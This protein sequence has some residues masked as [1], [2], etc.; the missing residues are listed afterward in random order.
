MGLAASNLDPINSE[1]VVL[2]DYNAG[3]GV[4]LLASALT[5]YHFGAAESTGASYSGIDMRAEVMLLSRDVS[6]T[7]STDEASKTLSHPEPW[8]CRVIVSDFFEPDL[9]YRAGS[10]FMDNVS[11]FNCSQADTKEAAL[12]F[13]N[14]I[15][16]TKIFRNGAISSGKG[17]GIHVINSRQVTFTDSVI[18]DFVLFGHH[19]KGSTQITFENNIMNGI[20]PNL[21]DWRDQ[22]NLKWP[23]PTGG[24][25]MV[26]TNDL[27][28][29]NN[30]AASMW[31]SGFRLPSHA[32]GASSTI[33]DNIAHS[34]SGMGVIVY[35]SAGPCSEFSS[36]RGYKNQLATVLMAVEGEN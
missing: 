4:A 1:T 31:H 3:T 27:V 23:I 6:I 8:G 19:S 5:G 13:N 36:F 32:C 35:S 34:I 20:R 28:F 33:T 21:T 11:I 26:G 17:E 16:G 24:W 22:E 18:H 10:I 14:A 2:T 15:Q 12:T 30:T 7:A 29:R 25:D 9:T